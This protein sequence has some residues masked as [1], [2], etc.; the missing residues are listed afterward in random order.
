MSLISLVLFGSRAREDNNIRSDIDLLL[1]SSDRHPRQVKINSLSLSFYPLDILIEKARNGDLFVLHIIR[2]G[3]LLN[4]PIEPLEKLRSS[5]KQKKSYKNEIH[6]A[7]DFGWMIIRHGNEFDGKLVRRRVTWC[8]RT[9]LIAVSVQ[10]GRPTFSLD[11]LKAI[12]P[13]QEVASLL[14]QKD[15]P[16]SND[17]FRLLQSFLSKCRLDDPCPDA[18]SPSDYHSHFERTKN[19]VA[20]HFLASK[21]TKDGRDE[22]VSG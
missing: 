9:I 21:H 18:T 6:A 16:I 3:R 1:I 14:Q 22:Y 4:G 2:E 8:V 19:A 20:L 5:F 13:S 11:G 12:D 10:R 15:D 7:G 17:T